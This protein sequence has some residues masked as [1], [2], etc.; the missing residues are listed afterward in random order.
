M[1]QH[2]VTDSYRTVHD[3]REVNGIINTTV[4]TGLNTLALRASAT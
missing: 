4:V 3:A 2:H 1:Y